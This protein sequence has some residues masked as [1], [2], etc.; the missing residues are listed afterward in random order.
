MHKQPEI[1]IPMRSSW[2][3]ALNR[4]RIVK[5]YCHFIIV[6]YENT[7][8]KIKKFYLSSSP[9]LTRRSLTLSPE[10]H[11]ESPLTVHLH[12]HQDCFSKVSWIDYVKTNSALYTSPN[13]P[14][15]KHREI[16]P[17]STTCSLLFTHGLSCEIYIRRVRRAVSII[18]SKPRCK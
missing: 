1:N 6:L 12:I 4:V 11:R 18:L 16:S 15:R 10:Y 7:T 5:F 3:I 13:I 14:Q 9:C 2:R 8:A 17:Q